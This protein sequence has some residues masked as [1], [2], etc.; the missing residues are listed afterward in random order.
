[1]AFV[2]IYCFIQ[3]FIYIRE[4]KMNPLL[5]CTFIKYLLLQ[6]FHIFTLKWQQIYCRTLLSVK[7]FIYI[8]KHK[9][10]FIT[11]RTTT[12]RNDLFIVVYLAKHKHIHLFFQNVYLNKKEQNAI[13]VQ[14]VLFI[15]TSSNLTLQFLY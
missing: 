15:N 1:M 12:L 5:A 3:R 10:R 6:T 8:T 11:C 7:C 2:Q 9:K 14:N 13:Q 4:H